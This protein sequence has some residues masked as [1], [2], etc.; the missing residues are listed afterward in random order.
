VKV[1][2]IMTAGVITAPMDAPLPVVA[3]LLRDHR[4]SAVPVVD[5]SGAVVGLVSEF[6]LLARDGEVASD[7]MTTS[8]ITVSPD[9][10]VDDVRHLLVERQIR[11]VPVLAGR[12]LVGII[13]RSDVVAVMAAEWACR[14]CGAT[15]RGAHPPARCPACYAGEEHFALQDPYPGS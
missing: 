3:A 8:V 5:G 10:E 4:I 7:I 14:V 1:R 9:T 15:V 13:S 6:D 2:D 12:D 11:R